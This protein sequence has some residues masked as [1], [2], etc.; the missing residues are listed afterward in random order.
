MNWE[1]VINRYTAALILD[2]SCTLETPCVGEGGELYVC[3]VFGG[4]SP[5]N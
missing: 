5:T 2:I 4:L 1:L 3:T